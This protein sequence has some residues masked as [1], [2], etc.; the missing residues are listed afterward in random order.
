MPLVRSFS[1]ALHQFMVG[2]ALAVQRLVRQ[3]RRSVTGPPRRELLARNCTEAFLHAALR[4]DRRDDVKRCMEMH[5]V[6]KFGAE[7]LGVRGDQRILGDGVE[8][9]GRQ[10]Q[11]FR[12][13]LSHGACRGADHATQGLFRIAVQ[14]EEH[15]RRLFRLG[16]RIFPVSAHV[17]AAVAARAVGI[18][19]EQFSRKIA[20]DAADLSQRNLKLLGLV[21]RCGCPAG[22]AP[23]YPSPR[24]GAR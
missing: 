2:A 20:R 7:M 8:N 16:S 18:D 23:P 19:Q 24:T 3:D 6:D 12:G 11:Q 13:G 4:G 17:S 21:P 10:F 5:V 14:T 22:D 15:L 1:L 9:L